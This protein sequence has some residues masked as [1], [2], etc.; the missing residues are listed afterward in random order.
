MLFCIII[1]TLSLLF[2]FGVPLHVHVLFFADK[3]VEIL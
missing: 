2:R 3:I 1:D